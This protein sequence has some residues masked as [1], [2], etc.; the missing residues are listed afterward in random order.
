[1][2]WPRFQYSLR[3][4]LIVVGLLAAA[5]GWHVRRMNYYADRAAAVER[6]KL[7]GWFLHGRYENYREPKLPWAMSNIVEFDKSKS[8]WLQSWDRYWFGDDSLKQYVELTLDGDW[9][10][11]V[12]MNP[13]ARNYMIL[14]R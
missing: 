7:N 14:S 8:T 10:L 9:E 13:D 3:T 4:F 12:Q 5:V 11:L 6:M 1:M 2:R